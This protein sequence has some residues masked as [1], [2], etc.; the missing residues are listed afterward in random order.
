MRVVFICYMLA[1]SCLSA[2]GQT[3][4]RTTPYGY[5]GRRFMVAFMQNE[6]YVENYVKDLYQIISISTTEKTNV[7][8]ENYLTGEVRNYNLPKDTV[9]WIPI[10][11]N[12]ENFDSEVGRMKGIEI[13]SDKPILVYCLSTQQ[14]TSDAYAAIPT[15]HWGR[16]Y[17][18]VSMPNTTWGYDEYVR[19]GEF[20][21][22]G[23]EDNTLVTYTP[24]AKTEK[25]NL[26]AE[27]VY[28]RLNKGET[29]LVQSTQ[30]EETGNDL[31]GTLINSDK[32]IGVLSGHVRT[33]MPNL[34][35]GLNDDSRNHLVEMLLPT[36]LWGKE[37]VTVPFSVPSPDPDIIKV[38]ALEP[39]TTVTVTGKMTDVT[40]E[41]DST[42]AY[43][44]L[45]P[46]I[47]PLHWVADKPISLVQFMPT[48]QDRDNSR[49]DASMVV[50][51][52][53]HMMMQEALVRRFDYRNPKHEPFN[54]HVLTI[55]CDS[56]ARDSLRL[57]GVLMGSLFP[58]I[59]TNTIPNTKYNFV[60]FRVPEGIQ[61]IT[62]K[63]GQF[64][65][66]LFGTGGEDAYSLT[67]G[68]ILFSQGERENIPPTI[69]ATTECGIINGVVRESAPPEGSF[70]RDVK[71][72]L[73]STINYSWKINTIYDTSTVVTFT[74][75]PV[76]PSKDG[77]FLVEVTDNLGNILFFRYKFQALGIEYTDTV[78]Y[79][80]MANGKECRFITVKNTGNKSLSLGGGVITG[81]KRLYF[82][83][84]SPNGV[85]YQNLTPGSSVTVEICFDPQKDTTALNASFSLN[86]PCNLQLTTSLLGSTIFPDLIPIGYDFGDVVL[87]DTNC[88]K[89]LFINSGNKSIVINKLLFENNNAF[90]VDTIG[91]FPLTLKKGD[92]LRLPVCFIPFER[93]SSELTIKAIN[94]YSLPDINAVVK[95]RGVAP[96]IKVF[97]L[98][99][100]SLR[101]GLSK[102]SSVVVKNIGNMKGDLRFSANSGDTVIF[103]DK[104]REVFQSVTIY[105]G[106]SLP[107][108][109]KFYA[110]DSIIYKQV[111]ILKVLNWKPHPDITVE[112]NGKGTIPQIKG[113]DTFFDTVKMH[114][115]KD[116]TITLYKSFGNEQL[117]ADSL[118]YIDGEK[119]VFIFDNTQL[120]KKV[121]QP[122]NKVEIPVRFFPKK[123][124]ESSAR[125]VIKSDAAK[126]YEK[127]VDTIT[128]V[129][130]AVNADTTSV[131]VDFVVPKMTVACTDTSASL[132]IRNSGNVAVKIDTVLFEVNGN[133]TVVLRDTILPVKGIA[134]RVFKILRVSSQG[135]PYLLRIRCNDTIIEEY[136]GIIKGINQQQYV[137]K[138]GSSKDTTVSIGNRYALRLEGGAIIEK[139]IPYP[140]TIN[141]QYNPNLFYLNSRVSTVRINTDNVS[142]TYTIPIESTSESQLRV[143][144]PAEYTK[145]KIVKW[146]FSTDFLVLLDKSKNDSFRVNV[147]SDKGECFNDV[148]TVYDVE[149]EPVCADPL[150]VVSS[151]APNAFLLYQIRPHPAGSESELFCA[152]PEKS[153]IRIEFIDQ[154]GFVVLEQHYDAEKGFNEIKL[155]AQ[156]LISGYYRLQVHSNYGVKS[157]PLIIQR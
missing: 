66:T 72:R 136:K 46:F 29:Y 101:V 127:R 68:G 147:V 8:I 96:L 102:D 113:F 146:N 2:W 91:M 116:T 153:P 93:S 64:T 35:L 100:G 52:P 115:F 157:L 109:V 25:N 97:S 144:V 70:I 42:G 19:P 12:N 44:T 122:Y 94:S 13:T 5:A 65:G 14:F 79:K 76:N 4:D 30:D 17:I 80:V 60:V 58:S 145:G 151:A 53:V 9:V 6:L 89:V 20:L 15:I 154:F 82:G 61:K 33:P 130:F 54:N 124:G 51:P 38:I 77:F 67:L 133:R 1:L 140:F 104:F 143:N 134:N 40:F 137:V 84:S 110:V 132:M 142:N 28:I 156:H 16:E 75:S 24:T 43:K 103:E 128:F 71:V 41:L 149:I 95:G 98:D 7:K 11:N 59:Y 121:T 139:E 85:P 99:M 63:K 83:E 39:N 36:N 37:Y 57:N 92:T 23:S 112:L 74:A 107:V 126:S 88:K 62:T 27:P 86:L 120:K 69:Y 18:V 135:T 118:Y 48:S 152:V 50:I 32:P 150:R 10:S 125:Y 114:R 3:N 141:I 155:N 47:E 26:V 138:E 117:T 73:D 22:I 21:I 81:D 111:S 148:N 131:S 106:D 108:K 56:I 49:Y 123:L 78:Q 87:G 31:T 45:A 129:G 55:L 90:K 34:I 119:D 105:P